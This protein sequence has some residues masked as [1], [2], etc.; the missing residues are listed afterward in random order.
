MAKG[1]R[2]G[3]LL[4]VGVDVSQR[5]LAVAFRTATGALDEETFANDDTGIRSLVKRVETGGHR[6]RIGIEATG[7]YGLAVCLALMEAH[8]E[9][10]LIQPLAARRFAQACNTR[11]K[12]DRVDARVLLDFAERMPFT[13]W[14]PPSTSLRELRAIAARIQN[15][16]ELRTADLNRQHALKL[17]PKTPAAVWAD[18]EESLQAIERRIQALMAAALELIHADPE[19]HE[20]HR[21]VTSTTGFADRSAIQIL[22]QLLVLPADLTP[23]QVVA[24][25]GLDP[26]T[27]QSGTSVR[28]AAHISRRGNRALRCALYMPTLVA[29]QRCPSVA[30]AYKALLDRGKPKKVAQ[31]ALMRR[32][33]QALWHMLRTKQT[34]DPQKFG[35]RPIAA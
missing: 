7:T 11:A 18:L 33:L 34:W 27:V 30:E 35:Q 19:L 5:T 23:R 3:A 1:K 10:M 28:G 16:V 29:I 24:F 9:V 25:A 21:I 12:T 31:I 14:M 22:A 2:E 32:L 8:H 4:H 20:A 17:D 26:Q 15:L 13:P 6:R